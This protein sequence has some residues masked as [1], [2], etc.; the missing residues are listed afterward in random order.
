MPTSAAF[1]EE[2]YKESAIFLSSTIVLMSAGTSLSP[3]T[4]ASTTTILPSLLAQG[5]ACHLVPGGRGFLA[6]FWSSMDLL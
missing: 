6:V 1:D 4:S 2:K 5:L 3:S